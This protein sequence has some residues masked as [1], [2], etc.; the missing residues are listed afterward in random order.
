MLCNDS[1]SISIEVNEMI[2]LIEF[3]HR[4]LEQMK[5]KTS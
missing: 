1:E 3:V 5:Q 2:Q 4:Y